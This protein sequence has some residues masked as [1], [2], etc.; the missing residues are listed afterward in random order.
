MAPTNDTKAL[1]QAFIVCLIVTSLPVKNLAYITPAV[2]LA[3]LWF[4]G[5]RRLLGRVLMVSSAILMVSSLAILWD[6][7]NGQTVNFPGLWLALLTYAPIFVLVCETFNRTIDE[8]AYAKFAKVCAWFILLQSLVGLFQFAATHNSDA[9]CGTLGLVDGFNSSVTIIQV[10]FTFILFAMMLFL[11]PAAN[12]WLNRTAIVV[13]ALT[14][15]VAQSGHQTV[16][17]LLTII[18]CA[19][20]R[21]SHIGT[22]VRTL[23]A[24][25][26]LSLLVYEAYPDTYSIARG[27][28]LK[29]TDSSGSPKRLVYDGALSILEDPKNMLIGTGLGQYSSRASLMTSNQYLNV[30]LPDFMVG[31][32]DYFNDHIAP[33]LILFEEV[34]EGSAMAK[35]YMTMVSLPV[36]LGLVLTA[37]LVAIVGFTIFRCAR[38]M[39]TN[40]GEVG[41]IGFVMMVG[42]I[43]FVL[44][45]FIENYAEFTQAIF[46]PFI[47]FVV[48]GSRARTELRSRESGA[49]ARRVTIPESANR[50]IG[51]ASL[52][53]RFTR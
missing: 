22:L 2:Y 51:L 7:L 12:S 35:P 28:Y 25:A 3:I 19:L 36:E 8:A 20:A 34:G 43:F 14:C 30:P 49:T 52:S 26:A 32:S 38:L 33:S 39:T 46:I 53:P 40:S 4:Y 44:C 48:A 21:V 16:F 29:I 50:R 10:Y 18:A 6:H 11:A 24:A 42:I 17:F 31:K 15:V 13:G 45:C 47:L 9:V 5:E 27:W 41:W 1:F 23:I 37:A